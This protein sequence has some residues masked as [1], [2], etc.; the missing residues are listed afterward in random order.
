MFI[1]A[2]DTVADESRKMADGLATSPSARPRLGFVAE[3]GIFVAMEM[4]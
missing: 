2:L 4:P 3:T 1:P